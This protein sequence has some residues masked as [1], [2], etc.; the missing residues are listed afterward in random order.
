MAIVCPGANFHF[1]PPNPEPDV[2]SFGRVLQLKK[3]TDR[4]VAAVRALG[5]ALGHTHAHDPHDP[6]SEAQQLFQTL[7]N[8]KFD[9]RYVAIC[10]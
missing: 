1:R 6:K 7:S 10:I 4:D 9:P 3:V 2:K 8:A 5:A